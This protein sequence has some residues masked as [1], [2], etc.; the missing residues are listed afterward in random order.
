MTAAV[1]HA[2]RSI[3]AMRARE[4]L[5]HTSVERCDK[6]FQ[7]Q[8]LLETR[9]V[10]ERLKSQNSHLTIFSPCFATAY[11]EEDS[12]SSDE[13]EIELLTP[14]LHRNA[15]NTHHRR[16]SSKSHQA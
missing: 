10:L 6:H 7:Q 16:S 5:I 3:R 2:S 13:D 9:R 4:D 14:V 1:K 11:H 12:S 8:A 15:Q